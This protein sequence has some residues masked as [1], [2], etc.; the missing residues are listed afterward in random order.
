MLDALAKVLIKV[1]KEQPENPLQFLHS[2]LA[3]SLDVKYQLQNA[4]DEVQRLK[5]E[6]SDLKHQL[7][8]QRKN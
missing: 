6:N 5:S 4:L 1:Q 3:P 2:C 8:Q 7:Q